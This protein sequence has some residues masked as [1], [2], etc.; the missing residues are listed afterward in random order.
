MIAGQTTLNLSATVLEAALENEM[1]INGQNEKKYT[2]VV[3]LGVTGL[4][5]VRY[6]SNQ[7]GF[8]ADGLVVVDSRDQPPCLVE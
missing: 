3:G 8:V 6:L 1:L 2:L 7:E 5:V 4:S